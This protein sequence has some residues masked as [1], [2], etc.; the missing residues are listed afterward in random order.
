MKIDPAITF[1]KEEIQ[2][3]NKVISTSN[4][5]FDVWYAKIQKNIAEKLLI[6]YSAG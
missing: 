5:Y 3:C 4:D 6:K 2:R 1:L